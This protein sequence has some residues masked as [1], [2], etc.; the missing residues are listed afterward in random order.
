MMQQIHGWG[1]YP[2][3]QAEVLTPV[4]TG[5]C[6]SF[7][8]RMPLIARGM[9]RSY[10]D[11][12]TASRVLETKWLDHCLHFDRERGII[13]CE[14]GVLLRD[15]IQVIV[16]AGWFLPVT[17]GTSFVSIGGAIASDVHGKNH[18]HAGTFGEHVLQM[19]LLLASG[20][21]V[22]A[23]PTELP[24]LYHATCGGMGLTGIILDAT[25]QLLPVSS[26]HIVQTT[27][28]TRC[29]EE[30]CEA[31]EEHAAPTYSVAWIDCLARGKSLGRS[32]LRLG[33]HAPEGPREPV[34]PRLPSVPVHT[35]AALLNRLTMS[36]FNRV[37]YGIARHGRTETVDLMPFFYPLDAIG[38]WNRLY[39]K[40]GFVQYQFV[41]PMENGV[42]NFRS[43]L[44][45]IADSGEGSVLAVLKRFGRENRNL[46]SF[47]MYGYTLAL[48]FKLNDKVVRLLRE[49]DAMV[50]D[51]G[52]RLYLA[53][54]ALMDEYTFKR[55]YPRW[56]AFNEICRKYGA[57]DRFASL[58]SRRLG[59]TSTES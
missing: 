28:K 48:D 44:S 18:H 56:E 9:G 39:G 11:A 50:V 45:R 57:C 20:E 49:L 53:K 1:G 23:S 2:R 42:R 13:R 12:A 58:Q 55:T 37:Y 22:T 15:L 34:V 47:P 29:L 6:R 17:P 8:D 51:M 14:A 5:E 30:I 19:S 33:E 41:I 26:A 3:L 32:V 16:P 35:P 10:G 54:D 40:A 21:T 43:I 52:G 38:D 31:F 59:L 27:I 36:N 24:D 7:A 25:L 46:L 4:S